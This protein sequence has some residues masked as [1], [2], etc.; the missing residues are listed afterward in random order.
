MKR[1]RYL[2]L[3]MLL[4]CGS[5]GTWAQDDDFDPDSPTEPGGPI[6]PKVALTLKASPAD[7]GT[8]S[9]GGSFLPGSTVALH[10]Y[11]STGFTFVNWTK[12]DG[13]VISVDASFGYTVGSQK[14]T[15]TA[16]FSFNPTNP[17]SPGEIEQNVRHRLT[18]VAEEG[19][20]VSGSGRYL[21]GTSVNIYAWAE[22]GFEFAGWYDDNGSCYSTNDSYTINMP[23]SHLTL[24]ARFNFVPNAPGEPGRIP[25][26]HKLVLTADEGGTVYANA[27]RLEEGETTEVTAYVNSGYDFNGWYRNG[28]LLTQSESFTYTMGN[29]NTELVARFDFN[30]LNPCEPE[31]IQEKKY[32]F[33][34]MNVIGMPGQTVT[35]PVYLTTR[36]AASNMTFRLSFPSDMLPNMESFAVSGNTT[37]YTVNYSGSEAEEGRTAYVFTLSG[38]NTPV[39]NT[40]LLSFSVTIPENAETA[41]SYPVTI[42]QVSIADVTGTTQTAG[43]RNG[44]ISVYKRGDTNGDN[45]VNSADVLNIVSVALEKTTEVFIE[46]VSD[47]NSDGGIS[48]ADVLGI[49]NIVLEK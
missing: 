7:G 14:E 20:N 26:K 8:V 24:T 13:T 29:T 49:V 33:Y 38:G 28:V 34:L 9:G 45:E 15:L 11:S 17:D 44:R 39:G 43:T 6:T 1:I 31:K 16:N 40:A 37:G 5:I 32:A 36:E 27:Y 46:E 21:P 30:P 25:N 12:A 48:S 23:A 2:T 35:F 4:L 10:A 41:K 3:L 19:G 18:L 42:N 22:N 47:M